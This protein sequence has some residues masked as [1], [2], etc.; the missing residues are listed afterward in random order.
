MDAS[1]SET[2]DTAGRPT[3]MIDSSHR[4]RGIDLVRLLREVRL[5]GANE[6]QVSSCCSDSRVCRPGDLYVALVGT[7]HDGHEHV[8]EAIDRG[9]SAVVAERYLPISVPQ[10]V[11]PDSRIAYGRLCQALVGNPSRRLRVVGVTGTNGKTTTSCLLTSVLERAGR[12]TSVMGTF[13]YFD[14]ERTAPPTLTTPAA[15]TL[16]DTLARSLANG[17]QHAVLEISSHALAQHRTAGIELDVAC[18]TGVERDH[19]DF[20]NTLENY[21][22]AKARIFDHL[23]GDGFAVLNVDNAVCRR[24]LE[25]LNCPV[26]TVALHRPAELTATVIER[27]PSEQTFL[28]TAGTDTVPVRTHIIGDHHVYNCLTA[29]AVGLG[30][31]IDLPTIVAGLEGIREVPGR[32]QRIE[33]GQ[34][35]GVFVDY[36]HTPDALRTTLATLREVTAGRL[37]CVFG[38]GGQRDREKRPLMGRAVEQGADVAIITDDNPRGEDPERIARDLLEGFEG[39]HGVEV[40]RDRARA[41]EQALSMAAPGDSVVIA[42]K[43]HERYQIVGQQRFHF[44]DC[45]VVRKWLRRS[46]PFSLPSSALRRAA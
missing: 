25:S 9:A 41:I 34:P 35:F 16:A 13:G 45:E 40:E 31:G 21:H 12:P 30:Y 4:T 36:A 2:S 22:A 46:L 6:L 37:I 3:Q 26:L 32:L 38:A 29:A 17:C 39:F 5:F 33:C 23:G 28:L 19:L 7:Q 43:G 42:G 18:V 27:L 1:R 15:P 11:V 24:F 14:G 44:D 8:Y 10:A 20:H